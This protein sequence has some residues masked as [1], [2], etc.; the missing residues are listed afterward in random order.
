MKHRH[1]RHRFHYNFKRSLFIFLLFWDSVVPPETD[2]ME[3]ARQMLLAHIV[4]NTQSRTLQ[5]RIERFCR[6]VVRFAPCEL[7]LT[8]VHPIMGGEHFT[9]RAI[10][11][12]LIGHQMRALVYKAFDV[13]QKVGELV[14]FH[15]HSPNRAVALN[16]DKHSLLL[17]SPASFMCYAVLVARLAADIFFVQFD[18]TLQRR[19]QFRSGIH[20]FSDGMTEFPGAFLRD[21]DPFAQINRGDSLARIND[22]VHGKQPLPKRKL[23]AVHG[24]FGCHS[25]LPFAL[26]TFI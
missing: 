20:H 14:T 13:R 2:F 25:K 23:G 11:L 22:V 21:T 15:R 24:R 6:V 18:N 3:I 16:S 1:N 17:G 19:N 9:R 12:K 5:V 8:V 26:G 10:A 7:F 4:E